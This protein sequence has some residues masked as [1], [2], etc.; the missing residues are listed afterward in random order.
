[1]NTLRGRTATPQREGP[2]TVFAPDEAF[3][4]LP[5]GS[6]EVLL[7]DK[8]ALTYHLVPS[9]AMSGD[10]ATMGSVT[11]VQ[12]SM[13]DQV[14]TRNQE[15]ESTMIRAPMFSAYMS[16]AHKFRASGIPATCAVIALSLSLLVATPAIA[17]PTA[18]LSGGATVVRF[19]DTF[20][21]ALEALGV[22][23]TPEQSARIKG[24]YGLFPIPAGALDLESLAGDIL[25]AGGLAIAAGPTRVELLSF[26]IDTT[27]LAEGN[28]APDRPVITGIVVANGDVFGRVPLF[29]LVLNQLP[30]VSP[31]G[32]VS[33]R[34]VDVLLSVEAADALNALFQVDAFVEGLPIGKAQ[35]QTRVLADK[36]SNGKRH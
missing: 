23:V 3:A 7:P 15:T 25:H 34:H 11:T 27:S 4:A 30:T 12:G 13:I 21:G 36:D 14:L 31:K 9:P 32:K 17:A 26:I 28:A 8:Q 18:Q 24:R 29:D 20:L 2:F 5:E 19:S 35:V 1:M 16:I 22:T 6:L 10:L 33:V